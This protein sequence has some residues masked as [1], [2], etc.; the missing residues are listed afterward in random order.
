MRTSFLGTGLNLAQGLD[1]GDSVSD[2]VAQTPMF[3]LRFESGSL[4][5]PMG[6]SQKGWVW[7]K[8]C[9]RKNEP[10]LDVRVT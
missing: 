4:C 10:H 6:C 9:P 2:Y 5:D 8:N 1:R 7:G 3:N